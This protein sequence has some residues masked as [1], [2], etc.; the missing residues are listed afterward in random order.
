MISYVSRQVI[1]VLSFVPNENDEVEI[2]EV[3]KHIVKNKKMMF[4][5]WL[6]LYHVYRQFSTI[7]Q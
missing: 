4:G 6:S 7:N 1:C 2:G 3:S 5:D